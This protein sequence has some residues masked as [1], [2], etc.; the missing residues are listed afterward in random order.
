M[1]LRCP[2]VRQGAVVKDSSKRDMELL[3]KGRNEAIE[4]L[5]RA[6]VDERTIAEVHP[7]GA[8]PGG[9]C[10]RFVKSTIKTFTEIKSLSIADASAIPG[11]FGVPP[12]LT[13]IAMS[14]RLCSLFLGTA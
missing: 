13:I 3:E 10:S 12:M 1:L 4:M 9:T 7:R 2:V 6:G 14:K 8:H 5:L 11:P